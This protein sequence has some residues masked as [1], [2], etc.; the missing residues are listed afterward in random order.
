MIIT[1]K[2]FNGGVTLS[3]R[4]MEA[5]WLALPDDVE[6]YGVLPL[7]GREHLDG[8]FRGVY[9]GSVYPGEDAPVLQAYGVEYAPGLYLGHKK[10]LDSAPVD[11]GRKPRVDRKSVV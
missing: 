6:I 3:Y 5:L 8:F 1:H 10:A 7:E 4:I 2:P 9:L 11:L